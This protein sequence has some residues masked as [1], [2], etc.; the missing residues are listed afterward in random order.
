[1]SLNPVAMSNHAPTVLALDFDGVLCNG[2]KEYFQTAWRAYCNLWQ[3]ED[4][5]PPN[6]LAERFYRTRPVIETGWEMPLLVR[7]LLLNTPE[8]DILLH[9]AAIANQQAATDGVAAAQL[10]NEIDG[11]RDRWITTDVKSWLAEHE[12]YPGIIPQ[13]QTWLTSPLEVIIISTKE[14]RFIQQLLQQHSVDFTKLKILGKEVKRSK[15][16]TLRSLLVESNRAESNRAESNSTA[17]IW[18]VEDRLQTL[19]AVCRQAD[20]NEVKLFLAAWGYNTQAERDSTAHE[21]DIHLLSLQQFSQA[22]TTWL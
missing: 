12:F 5:T 13:L 7:S 9:W 20:L 10:A 4:S 6:G 22:L 11:V 16:E 8:A 2:M 19:Q 14:G 15:P 17:S 18:F 1:M 3:P 21:P